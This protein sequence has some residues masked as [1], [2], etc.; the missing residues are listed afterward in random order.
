MKIWCKAIWDELENLEELGLIEIL[1]ENEDCDKL[2]L[3]DNDLVT[4]VFLVADEDI[5]CLSDWQGAYPTSLSE[6]EDYDRWEWL[7]LEDVFY[8]MGIT[9]A[10]DDYY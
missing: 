8:G 6:A 2:I 9:V 5:S 10:E 3:M 4:T 1:D 7:P